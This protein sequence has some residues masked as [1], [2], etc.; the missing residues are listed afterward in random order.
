MFLKHESITLTSLPDWQRHCY[1][2][3]C[4]FA[5]DL[6]SSANRNYVKRKGSDRAPVAAYRLWPQPP[7][8]S[9]LQLGFS[10]APWL[11]VHAEKP[12]QRLDLWCLSVHRSWSKVKHSRRAQRWVWNP[13]LQQLLH[14]FLRRGGG[15]RRHLRARLLEVGQMT[16]SHGN[17]RYAVKNGFLWT[18]CTAGNKHAKNHAES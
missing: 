11:G 4:V 13:S 9:H 8:A 15:V 5:G 2:T 17:V 3:R 18:V 1:S 10:G 7:L 14:S 6:L 16:S 12:Q